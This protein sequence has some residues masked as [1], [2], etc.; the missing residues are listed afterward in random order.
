MFQQCVFFCCA[1]FV[2]TNYVEDSLQ[3]MFSLSAIE[4]WCLCLCVE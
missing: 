4:L 3:N 1:G 2:M